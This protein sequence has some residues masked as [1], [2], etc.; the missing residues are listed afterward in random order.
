[1]VPCR[2]VFCFE[3]I[4]QW[5]TISSRCPKCR[6]DTVRT[7]MSQVWM[8]TVLNGDERPQAS[9]SEPAEAAEPAEA[10]ALVAPGNGAHVLPKV[11]WLV[12]FA[13]A[14]PGEPIVVFVNGST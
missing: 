12:E 3:C 14:R 7:R 2:H 10:R 11:E 13:R 1:M 4:R 8:R 5:S 6:A 9:S